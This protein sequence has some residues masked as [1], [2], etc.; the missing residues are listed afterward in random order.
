MRQPFP[1]AKICRAKNK[2]AQ[3]RKNVAQESA[4]T[5]LLCKNRDQ[6]QELSFVDTLASGCIILSA[7]MSWSLFGGK[8]LPRSV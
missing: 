1:G 2:I 5:H 3:K 8:S 4:S 7:F 6:F